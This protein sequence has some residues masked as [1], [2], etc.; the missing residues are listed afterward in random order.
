[1]YDKVIVARKGERWIMTIRRLSGEEFDQRMALSQFAFQFRLSEADLEARRRKWRPEHDWGYFDE[2]GRLL[3]AAIVIPF[4]TWI[5]GRKLAMGGV[6]GVAT[7]P[8]A[9]RQ[10]CVKKLLAHALEAMRKDGQTVSML[11][12]F[13]FA[14]YRKYGWEMTIER[15]KYTMWTGQLPKRADVPGQVTRL[16]KPDVAALNGIYEAYASR[17]NGTLVR[18]D[19]WWSDKL[20]SKAGTWAVYE[21]ESGVPEGYIF[22]DVMDRKLT[23]HDWSS[24]TETARVALWSYV[25][26]HDSMIDEAT[27]IVPVDDPLTFLLADPRIKQEIVPYFMTRIVDAEAFVPLCAWGPG[28]EGESVTLRLTDEYA[29]WNDGTFKLTWDANGQGELVRVASER[30]EEGPEVACDIQGLTAM[31][32]GNRRP[33]FLREVGRIRGDDRAIALLEQRIP[34][35]TT[36]LMDFF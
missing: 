30:P 11:H 31:L 23:V 10:G 2:S 19:E 32:L 20:F 27:L 18:S 25:G 24:V 34:A 22:Y 29:A 1:M 12:P 35:R 16:A 15:K 36:H 33:A 14:F 8:D 5:H 17:Y 4:E 9:R 7:W 6:A 13:A 28:T 26:N 3:S 21:N